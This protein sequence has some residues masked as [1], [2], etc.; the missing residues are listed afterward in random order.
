M[1][2]EKFGR[3]VIKSE[4]G[5][6]GMATV[7]HA[8]DPRFERDVA[9][10]VLPEVFLH[11]PHFRARFEREAKTIALLEHPAIVPVYDFG[12]ENG[13]PYIVMRYMSGGS[14]ADRL[15]EGPMP[16]SEACQIIT[17]LAPALDAAHARGIIHRDLKP[18][19]ILFDQYGNAFLSDF[20][21]AR[22]T[23]SGSATLTGD[24]IVG[25]PAY[26]SPE[27][28]QGA[29]NLDGR[30][31]IYALSVIFFQMLSGVTPY[32]ADTPA[33]VMM[34]HMLEPVPHILNL[35]SDLPTAFD[36]IIEKGMAKEPD[37]RFATT[38]EMASAIELANRGDTVALQTMLGATRI[39]HPVEIAQPS[40]GM[41]APTQ[42]TPLKTQ[43]SR[44][45]QLQQVTPQV[46][47]EAPVVRRKFPVWAIILLVGIVLIGLSG[48]TLAG[49]WVLFPQIFSPKT[50]T[51]LAILINP[52]F[53]S[54]KQ[55][56]PT[57]TP[58]ETTTKLPEPSATSTPN[59]TVTT[60]STPTPTVENTATETPTSPPVI[61]EIGGADK[62]AFLNANNVW[63]SDVNG[64]NPVQLTNDG[65]AKSH[66]QWT[67]DGQAIIFLT[68]KCVR[69]VW[70][71]NG[72]VDDIIC[73]ETA[74]HLDAFE[75]SRDG[76]RVAIS[77]DFEL[78]I[79]RYDLEQIKQ[80][81]SRNQLK[82]LSDCPE[83]SPYNEKIVKTARW[84]GDG[85]SLAIVYAAPE[86]GRR[87]DTIGILDIRR[88]VDRYP[89]LDNFPAT[90]FTMTGYNENPI[91]QNFTW[92]GLILFALN[93]YVRNGGFGDLY[94]YNSEVHKLQYVSTSFK[95]V[96]PIDNTCCYRDPAW[97]PDGK[98]LIFAFQDIR[99]G[100]NSKI[101]LY[102]VQA[103]TIGTGAHY[104]PLALPEGFFPG[105]TEAPWPALRPVK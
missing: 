4:V 95:F 85:Q 63:I 57:L 21:I 52:T 98:Y 24:S 79:V 30:S 81:S 84:S 86:G 47:T 27:Q 70:M 11:D 94:I 6:G 20:G 46:I 82:N 105:R 32:Q 62:V 18:G 54:T 101:Q 90:R 72:R 49:G 99:Q 51:P 96:N 91:I 80:I 25:T 76:S 8:Y 56:S 100:D 104:Q 92:N 89:T 43:V 39:T 77:I 1:S 7:Y 42:A 78:Y 103:G 31:D 102:Y 88:C 53:T 74:E 28:I 66:L 44:H 2:S 64:S 5:R 16:I 35:K 67:P 29:K 15:N 93:S 3:Y 69:M 55:P 60:T 14:L 83:F 19:N 9:I 65:A 59:P 13:Q 41:T 68:G 71:D 37:Q 34:M 12:E 23:E 33:S 40:D 22:L 10:K 97:S 61:L 45:A 38:A 26:M 87:L 50:D 75:V 48:I 17:R 58:T 36:S 73:F